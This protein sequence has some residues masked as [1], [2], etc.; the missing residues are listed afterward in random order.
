M[1]AHRKGAP[2]VVHWVDFSGVQE[3]S[4]DSYKFK[5]YVIWTDRSRSALGKGGLAAALE[6]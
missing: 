4:T 5:T 1:V 2:V 6:D 3:F